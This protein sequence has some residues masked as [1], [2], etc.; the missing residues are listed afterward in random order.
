MCI[1]LNLKTF[2]S[3][4]FVLLPLQIFWSSP[5]QLLGSFLWEE[6]TDITFFSSPTFSGSFFHSYAGEP[7]LQTLSSRSHFRISCYSKDDFLIISTASLAW[8]S[9][10]GV[11][12]KFTLVFFSVHKYHPK[13]ISYTNP[14]WH[15]CWTSSC[16]PKCAT[17]RSWDQMEGSDFCWSILRND[18]PQELSCGDRL[19]KL[20]CDLRYNDGPKTNFCF[21]GRW[22]KAQIC[23]G[24]I[25]TI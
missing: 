21:H 9:G 10:C 2:W 25:W 4:I 24:E 16:F 8:P 3:L 20:K 6:A 5:L 15:S 23:W 13:I 7:S 22:P 18:A 11:S 12:D 1:P 14:Q 19:L 17:H